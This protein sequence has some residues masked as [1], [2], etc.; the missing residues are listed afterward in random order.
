MHICQISLI[1]ITFPKGPSHLKRIVYKNRASL[2][3]PCVNYRNNS[4]SPALPA[5][6]AGEYQKKVRFN[7]ARSDKTI[8]TRRSP[9]NAV[10]GGGILF[11]IK[12]R[13]GGQGGTLD[14]HCPDDHPF[15][16]T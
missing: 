2:K 4:F 15:L 9:P 7:H 11:L 16:M 5:I 10:D 14:P 13:G 6:T 1:L 12:K 8:F 3:S